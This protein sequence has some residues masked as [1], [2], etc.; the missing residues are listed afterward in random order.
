MDQHLE[1]SWTSSAHVALHSQSETFVLCSLA[2][3]ACESFVL[4][5]AEF[6]TPKNHG[7]QTLGAKLTFADDVTH[8]N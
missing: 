8:N 4:L 6:K 5:V 2:F 3:R 1:S 7:M